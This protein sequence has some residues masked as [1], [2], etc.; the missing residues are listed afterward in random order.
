MFSNDE[1]KFSAAAFMI[2]QVEL[3]T[4]LGFYAKPLMNVR[5]RMAMLEC[6]V[7]LTD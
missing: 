3:E 5:E 2:R 7:T 1:P 4:H 6:D